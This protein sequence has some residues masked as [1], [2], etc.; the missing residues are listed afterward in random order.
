MQPYQL[1]FFVA[2]RETIV[3]EVAGRMFKTGKR[4][5]YQ[6]QPAWEIVGEPIV[7]SSGARLTTVRED[8]ILPVWR[9]S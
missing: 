7:T 3:A 1:V 4:S 5:E 6:N 8:L 2:T 9:K